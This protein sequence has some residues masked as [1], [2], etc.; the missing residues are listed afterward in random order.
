[1]AFPN[2]SVTAKLLNEEQ[3]ISYLESLRWPD[4]ITC[5]NCGN[6]KVSRFQAKGKTGKVRHIC[7]CLNKECKYQFSVTTG[8]IFHDSHLPLSEWFE[9][10]RILADPNAPISVNQLRFVLDVQYK[11][12]KNVADRI[13]HALAAGTVEVVAIPA[14]AKSVAAQS[15]AESPVKRPPLS[16]PAMRPPSI[17]ISARPVAKD[18]NDSIKPTAVTPPAARPTMVDNMLSVFTSAVNLSVKPPLAAANYLKKK[19]LN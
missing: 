16:L 2:P 3:C 9:A 7:Q 5:P 6:K 10:M 15:V 13:Q 18:R 12:A 1:M 19:I 14:A 17:P 4:G 11:T 8:S